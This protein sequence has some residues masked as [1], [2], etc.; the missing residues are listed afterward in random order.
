MLSNSIN[1]SE[2]MDS[3]MSAQMPGTRGAPRGLGIALMGLVA[4]IALVAVAGPANAAATQDHRVSFGIEP[5]VLPKEGVRP[6]FDFGVTS[7]AIVRDRAAVVNYSGR[8][9]TLQVYATDALNTTTGG[10]SLLPASARPS[11]AGSWVTIPA[12]YATVRVPAEALGRPGHIVVPFTVRVPATAT[13]GD[14]VGGIVASL[15]T[16]GA[17]AS[18]Q[19][20]VLDQRTGSRLFIRVAGTLAPRVTVGNLHADYTATVN[21]VGRG[22]VR[23]SYVVTNSGNVEY[24]LRQ[25]VSTHSFLGSS[26]TVQV[27]RVP[28]LLPGEALHESVVVNGVWPQVIGKATVHVTPVAAPGDTDPK[29]VPVSASTHFLEVPW[30]LIVLLLL[31]LALVAAAVRTMRRRGAGAA[32]VEAAEP[33]KVPA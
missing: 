24:G 32:D 16:T 9:L 11:G 17:N 25:A 29:L 27:A 13:P 33:K 14:H 28:L 15:Q 10:F 1:L 22:P 2:W 8:P 12:R 18:G 20:I 26:Q 6:D 3:V 4:W 30:A 5:V 21:P 7:G 23:I 19:R 31:L